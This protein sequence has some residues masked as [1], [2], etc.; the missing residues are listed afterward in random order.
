MPVTTI[1]WVD[2]HI[3]MVDQ[4]RLPTEFVR[5]EIKEIDILA[6]AIKS[7]RVRGAPAIGIAGAFGVL[8]ESQKFTSGDR[9]AFFEMLENT[10]TYLNATRLECLESHELETVS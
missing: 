4:T 8:L 9:A 5:L 3:R 1:E 7:L 2:D 6:E 10:V